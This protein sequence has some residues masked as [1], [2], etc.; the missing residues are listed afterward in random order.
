MKLSAPVHVLKD[1]AKKLKREQS[2]SMIDA[3]NSIAKREGF[4]SWSLLQSKIYPNTS[5]LFEPR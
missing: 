3:L 2:I 1:Q 4:S 5:R